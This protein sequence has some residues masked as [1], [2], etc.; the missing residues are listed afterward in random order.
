M[1][2]VEHEPIIVTTTGTVRARDVEEHNAAIKRQMEDQQHRKQE[3][4]ASTP[5]VACPFNRGMTTTCKT[6]CALY[7]PEGCAIKKMATKAATETAESHK[8]ARCPFSVGR[9]CSE[10]CALFTGA[11]CSITALANNL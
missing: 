11:V 2:I 5:T 10:S 1:E 7:S 6:A 9:A 4:E 3:A 8:G